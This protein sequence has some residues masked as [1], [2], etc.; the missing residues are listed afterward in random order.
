MIAANNP[1]NLRYNCH[2]NWKGQTGQ[3]RGFCVFTDF[4]YATR[5]VSMLLMRSYRMKHVRTY[6]QIIQRYAPPS[7]N[8]TQAY[9]DFLMVKLSKFPW[10]EPST[11]YDFA[12]LMYYIIWFEQG[13]KPEK[14]LNELN[15]LELIVRVIR[16]F[17]ISPYGLRR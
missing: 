4:D 5:A 13:V 10:D 1:Y 12:R 14:V 6:S 3:L 11:I 16:N 7:E 2:N 9:I 8:K 17:K 15:V